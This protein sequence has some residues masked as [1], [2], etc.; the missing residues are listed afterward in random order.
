MYLTDRI[1]IDAPR[2]TN[3][4]YMAATVKVA[5]TGIQQYL[6]SEVDPKNEHGM[7]DR[8]VV[9]IYRP[10]DEVFNADSMA[11]AAHRPVTV[12]HPSEAVTADNWRKYSVGM[13]GGEVARDGDFLV[14]PM[15]IMDADA[16][17][18]IESGKREISQGYNCDFDWTAGVTKDGLE[19]DAIQRN[20]RHNHTAIV[21]LA[22]GGHEL[23]IGDDMPDIK[24]TQIV[25]D[26]VPVDVNDAAKIIID[27]LDAKLA[28]ANTQIGTLTAT[29][30]TK[31]GELA[32]LR[33]QVADAAM[34]PAKLDAAVSAR[35]KV[36][37]AAKRIFP[38]IVTD[39]KTD[40]VIRKEA[41][42]HRM[43]DAATMDENAI[44][45]AFTA[46]AASAPVTDNKTADAVRGVVPQ[47]DAIKAAEAAHAARRKSMS[48]AWRDKAN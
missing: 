46:L 4:G 18:A 26:G 32:A 27:A 44:F 48:D 10:E 8:G 39:G 22:R 38:A 23:R 19:Y 1:T 7:R 11:T 13:V 34:T 47:G 24:L 2:R 12:D 15:A 5:R 28:A 40:A 16:I 30:S 17:R 9:R 25:R 21:G 20:I 41:V 45:G 43:A 35:A 42:V 37:D 36:I 3:D 6:P 33:Q 31:D 29:V 14:V